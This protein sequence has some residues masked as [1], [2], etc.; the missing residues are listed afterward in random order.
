MK[1]RVLIA[2]ELNDNIKEYLWQLKDELSGYNTYLNW[3]SIEKYHIT[4]SFLGEVVTSQFELIQ[5]IINK[6][7]IN[8]P[9][10]VTSF[11]K[12]QIFDIKNK[13]GILN[14]KLSLNRHF[15]N[16]VKQL[17]F[18]LKNNGFEIKNGRFNPHITILRIKDEYQRYDFS[19]FLS[20]SFNEEPFELKN[21]VLYQSILS[22]KGSK[23]IPLYSKKLI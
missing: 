18:N 4:L 23:Y 20:Y 9:P 15:E 16:L 13:Y 1:Q 11:E 19:S 3:E 7:S 14:V 22:P 17:N 6:I 8:N 21:I 12:F 2:F 5:N 10:V